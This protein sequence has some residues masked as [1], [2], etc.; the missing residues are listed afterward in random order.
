MIYSDKWYRRRKYIFKYLLYL[1][2]VPT[3]RYVFMHLLKDSTRGA[4]DGGFLG[5]FFGLFI[6]QVV[7]TL[8]FLKTNKLYSFL[9]GIGLALITI[10]LSFL[11]KLIPSL[12]Q[13][14]WPFGF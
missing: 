1:I 8:F 2:C 4:H 11:I 5:M 9:I 13:K 10:L 6:G 14:I 3:I 12:S 7:F